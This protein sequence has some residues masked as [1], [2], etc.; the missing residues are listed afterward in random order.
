MCDDGCSLFRM[1]QLGIAM[2]DVQKGLGLANGR[3]SGCIIA[4]TMVL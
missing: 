2:D 3:S 1:H 4:Y